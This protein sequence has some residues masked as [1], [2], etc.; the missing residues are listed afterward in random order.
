M[1]AAHDRGELISLR[2]SGTTGGPRAVVRTTSSWFDSFDRVADLAGLDARSRVWVPGPAQ[3]TMNLFALVHARALGAE[4]ASGPA[5]ATHAVLTPAALDRALAA[6]TPVGGLHLVVA[7]DRL[8]RGLHDRALGAGASRVSHYYGA[9]ELSFV[10]WGRH[11]ED[12][13]PFPGVD[14]DT[15]DGRIWVRS[16]LLFLRYDGPAG[17]LARREDGFVTVGDRGRLHGARLRVFGRGTD[18]VVTAG[19]TVLVADVETALEEATGSR[20]VVL[21]LPHSQLGQVLCAV[22]PSAELVEPLRAAAREVLDRAGRPRRWAVVASP[23]LTDAGKVDRAA[24][25]DVVMRSSP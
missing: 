4:P 11:A 12:L 24:L 21:G 23:P 25:R 2:T 3:S 22:V 5:G 9:A 7:G 10:A 20:P 19:A 6:G 1:L 18:A 13:R 14:V 15:D 16:D 17:P 8:G